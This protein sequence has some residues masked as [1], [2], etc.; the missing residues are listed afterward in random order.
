MLERGRLKN[1]VG[2][3]V[4]KPNP[5]DLRV[6][7]AQKSNEFLFKFMVLFVLAVGAV[8][9]M[10]GDVAPHIRYIG[11]A[12]VAGLALLAGFALFKWFK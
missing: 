7:K 10:T 5:D 3:L 2:S 11:F 9:P 6:R 4:A 1:L 8:T 12:C